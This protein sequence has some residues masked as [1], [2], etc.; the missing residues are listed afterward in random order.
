MYLQNLLL[1]QGI[2][3]EK[4]L[5][6]KSREAFIIKKVNCKLAQN[7]DVIK[8]GQIAIMKDKTKRTFKE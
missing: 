5:S 3:K 8:S 2:D 1:W 7:L 4:D 6:L